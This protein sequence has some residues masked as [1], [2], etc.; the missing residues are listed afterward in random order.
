MTSNI[1]N[2]VLARALRKSTIPVDYEVFAPHSGAVSMCFT[3]LPHGK[4]SKPLSF[5]GVFGQYG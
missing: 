1:I 2:P 3:V 5:V 4:Q